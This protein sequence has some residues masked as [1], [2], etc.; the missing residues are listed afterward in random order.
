MR[1]EGLAKWWKEWIAFT[2]LLVETLKRRD[3][4]RDRGYNLV[5]GEMRKSEDGAE[6]VER[7]LNRVLVLAGIQVGLYVVDGRMCTP[8]GSSEIVCFTD[9]SQATWRFFRAG[10][11]GFVVVPTCFPE[12]AGEIA[13]YRSCLRG[14]AVPSLHDRQILL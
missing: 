8:L 3:E 13:S 12:S 1:V 9:L 6:E 5:C 2:K 4:L 7:L 11:M 14:S 10:A